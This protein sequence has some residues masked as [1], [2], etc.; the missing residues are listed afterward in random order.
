ADPEPLTIELVSASYLRTLE[1]AP[2]I[3]RDL[4][5][6]D[7]SVPAAQIVLSYDLWQGRFGGETSVVGR[8]LWVNGIRLTIVGI[9]PRGFAGVSGQAQAWVPA[10]MA[11]QMTYADYLAT[12]QNFISVVARLRDGVT[13]ARA[14]SELAVLGPAIQRRNPSASSIPGAMFGA[15]AL[16][17]NDA[18]VDPTTRRPMLL[19]LGAAA[20]LLLLSCANVSAL[21]LGRAAARRREMAVRVATGASRAQIVRQMLVESLLLSTVGGAIGIA[22]TV[23]LA[24]LLTPPPAAAR[25]RNLYGS[26]AEFA[27]SHVDARVVAFCAA[28]CMATALVFGLLP[29]LRAARVDLSVDLKDGAA[30][31][32]W[33]DRGPFATRQL[34]VGLETM[35]AVVLLGCGGLLLV[36]WRR[37]AATDVGFDRSHMLTFMIRPSD[38]AYPAARAPALLDRVLAAAQHVPGVDA[39]SFDGCAPVGT[40]CANATLYI[41]GRPLPRPGEAPMVLRHYVAPDHFR[42]LRVPVLRGRAFTAADRGGAP[43]VAIINELAARRFWPNEDP[44][45]HRVWFGGG[46]SFDR[47]DSSAEI[48][49]IVGDVAYQQLDERPY[50]PD[51]YTPYS[52]FSYATR[53]V[54]VRTHGEPAAVVTDMRRAVRGVDPTL[55]LFDVRTMDDRV[56]A[57]WSRLTQQ[58]RLL[59]AFAGLALVLAA[60]GIFA[61]I[62]QAIGERRR[63]LGVR[64]AL[65]ASKAHL[66]AHAARRGALPAALGA[67][68]GLAASVAGGRVI[69]AAV[70]GAPAFEGSVTLVVGAAASIVIAVAAGLGARRALAIHPAEALR[71]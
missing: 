42:V 20:C 5:V 14:R 57:S 50:Q 13:L 62:A 44:I 11:A 63:E 32:G 70:H 55:A 3:G 15:T 64:A 6:L 33:S 24:G 54:L 22:V 61:V 59:G 60:T 48:V 26:V 36:T 16:A 65:G 18:R 47:P 45:G 66:L 69:A 12:N 52:Q 8:A 2:V 41:A 7:E 35:L 19:L 10:A 27:E 40:G 30:G 9:A 31:S 68:A 25:G 23:P 4:D 37:L 56:R 43:R 39:V 1:I 71:T 58:T 53:M 49:G 29:A 34:I 28:V 46:S 51:F 21:L 17:L 38:A 67:A